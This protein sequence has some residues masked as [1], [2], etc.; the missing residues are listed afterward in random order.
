[1]RSGVRFGRAVLVLRSCEKDGIYRKRLI[2]ESGENRPQRFEQLSRLSVRK[3]EALQVF[4]IRLEIEK[5]RAWKRGFSD[6]RD[7][8]DV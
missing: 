6:R 5:R 3:V 2:D 1:M 8:F 7:G 4:S